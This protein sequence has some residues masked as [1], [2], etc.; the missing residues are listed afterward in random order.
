[1]RAPKSFDE[2]RDRIAERHGRLAGRLRQIAEFALQHPNDLALGTVATVSAR[3]GVQPS[4]VIR[5]ANLFGFKGFI[6]LQQVFR[7]R[8]VA[9]SPSYRERIAAM[10]QSRNGRARGNATDPAHVLAEFVADG[11][12]A[13]EHLQQQIRPA[14]MERA[15]KALA[16][17]RDIGVLAQGRAFPVAF[18]L[19]YALRRL[20]QRSQLIDSLGGMAQPQAASL[21]KGDVLLAVSFKEYSPDVVEIVRDARARG[22]DVVAL[23][24]SPL[25]PIAAGAL[26][27][28]EV[29]EG[30]DTP[31]RS[32]VAPMCFAQ[33]LVVA[34]GHHLAARQAAQ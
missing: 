23:T 8:L 28:L 10:R 12:A 1:M 11:I 3:A 25:S 31:F 27:A 9:A 17:A 16:R 20:D 5:F 22:V 19:N 34:L 32:L 30:P 26:A 6:D 7:E 29:S 4:A 33:S 21:G 15:V 18:Y 2:L 13:L 14:E 24:D